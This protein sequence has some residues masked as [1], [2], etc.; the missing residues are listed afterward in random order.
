MT[1][2]LVP[3]QMVCVH[4]GHGHNV[5]HVLVRTF[6]PWF[7]AFGGHNCAFSRTENFQER[8]KTIDVMRSVS[9][10]RLNFAMKAR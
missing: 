4:E 2:Q 7:I 9:P 10:F 6:L 1:I 8:V 5:L 3:T